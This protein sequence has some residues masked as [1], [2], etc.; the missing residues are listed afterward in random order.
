MLFLTI[1]SLAIIGMSSA[2]YSGYIEYSGYGAG[3][4]QLPSA[5]LFLPG[6]Q[7]RLVVASVAS[8][9]SAKTTYI[10]NCND[11]GDQ[12]VYCGFAQPLTITEGPSTVHYTLA[13]NNATIT[14]DCSLGGTTTAACVQTEAGSRP[15]NPGTTSVTFASADLTS[16]YV[17]ATIVQQLASV[18]PTAAAAAAVN[19]TVA[20][21][22]TITSSASSQTPPSSSQSKTPTGT[23]GTAGLPK[24]TA[25]A[26][27]VVGGAAVMA[28]GLAAL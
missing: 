11:S 5:N 24:I 3:A 18:T 7:D 25:N 26:Q 23:V 27:W 17:G 13:Q 16:I 2:Q 9:D 10:V 28:L 4:G 19:G 8:S 6:F 15:P 22:P 20:L 14:M 1:T 12:G 21:F